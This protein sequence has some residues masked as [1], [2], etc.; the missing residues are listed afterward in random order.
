MIRILI[1]LMILFL[2]QDCLISQR[3]LQETEKYYLLDVLGSAHQNNIQ[4][5]LEKDSNQV[6]LRKW[7]F[8]DFGKLIEEMDYRG[9]NVTSSI[10]GFEEMFSSTM[11]SIYSYTYDSFG[12]KVKINKKD[13]SAVDTTNTEY[14]FQYIG[15]DTILETLSVSEKIIYG[16]LEAEF[17]IG[18]NICTLKVDDRV[19]RISSQWFNNGTST[20]IENVKYLYSKN[21][22]LSQKTYSY[23]FE[24]QYSENIE[25]TKNR[26]SSMEYRYDAQERLV[27]VSR[28]EGDNTIFDNRLFY[29]FDDR[30]VQRIHS[31]HDDSR[32][33][34]E[35]VIELLYSDNGLLSKAVLNNRTYFYEI[36]TVKK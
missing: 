7:V 30:K 3:T 35:I 1:T 18:L 22:K 31:K 20:G 25:R 27:R 14:H 9:S 16:D 26:L 32:E 2:T 6:V 15:N 11:M 33:P 29:D 28:Q 36:V 12:R 10:N 17:D 5:V 24:T 23:D 8:D 21:G 19:D 13:Y 4:E 34:Q